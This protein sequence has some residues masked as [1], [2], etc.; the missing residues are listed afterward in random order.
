[1]RIFSKAPIQKEPTKA[2][3]ERRGPRRR[4]RV[5]KQRPPRLDLSLSDIRAKVGDHFAEKKVDKFMK[6]T[7]AVTQGLYE[8]GVVKQNP[9]KRMQ[10]V[11]KEVMEG[12]EISRPSDVGIND[13]ND[14]TTI[15]KLKE[16]LSVGGV[17]FSEKERQVLGQILED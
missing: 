2:P 10:L 15:G 12:K 16:I 13:P 8:N 1:M 11:A 5:K 9:Q 7:K 4:S 17:N 6:K 14:P 3:E